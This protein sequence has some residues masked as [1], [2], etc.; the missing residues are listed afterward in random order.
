MEIGLLQTEEKVTAAFLADKL[1]VSIRTIYRDIEA[2][3][4]A[5]IPVIAE[6]GLSGGYSLPQGYKASM[7]GL[8]HMDNYPLVLR[9]LGTLWKDLEL[10]S[11]DEASL[12]I[13]GNASVLHKQRLLQFRERILAD[14]TGW[15]TENAQSDSFL[16]IRMAVMDNQS[17]EVVYE[18][19]SGK[20]REYTIEPY[21]LVYKAGV[22]YLVAHNN[23]KFKT[24]R[25]SRF[26]DVRTKD[27]NFVRQQNFLLDEY[28]KNSV[29]QYE[30]LGEPIEVT[31]SVAP[32]FIREI[33]L[34][35]GEEARKTVRLALQD[36]N[37][38]WYTINWTFESINT[39]TTKILSMGPYVRITEPVSAVNLIYNIIE[40]TARLYQKG[41]SKQGFGDT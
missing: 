21:G 19:A 3:C 23:E 31:L 7:N 39:M 5:G 4:M 28:W 10:K 8:M 34:Y 27:G 6:P 13:L 20:I 11:I 40:K 15:F 29:I 35:L 41:E 37:S 38:K 32:D 33:P 18:D 12:K 25:V 2:L 30:S 24:Y 16:L 1:G 9:Q 17:L 22:W 26:L 36:R 14:Q